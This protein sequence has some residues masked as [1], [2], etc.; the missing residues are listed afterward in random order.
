MKRLLLTALL[1]TA[2]PALAAVTPASSY[3]SMHSELYHAVPPARQDA[4]AAENAPQAALAPAAST[5]LDPGQG[6]HA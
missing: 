2:L 1:S 4:R 6:S 3:L 5:T